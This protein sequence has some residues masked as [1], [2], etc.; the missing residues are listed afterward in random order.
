V[1]FADLFC[2]AGG[3][4]AGLIDAGMVP[5]YAC[6]AWQPALDVYRRNLG[7]DAAR[8]DLSEPTPLIRKLMK[9]APDLIAGGPPCTEFSSAGKRVEGEQAKLMAR[10]AD[11]VLACRP[12]WFVMEN[13]SRARN[14]SI[15][16]KV[17]RRFER[18]GYGLTEE[19][20]DA[21]HCGIPQ[22]RRRLILVGRLGAADD[23]L[24]ESLIAGLAAEPMSIRDAL[25]DIDPHLYFHGRTY[26]RR[27]VYSIDGPA[28][29]I[30]GVLRDP[31]PGYKRHRL[32]SANP[33]E[34]RA[35]T[36]EEL[37]LIQG[38]PP[39]W[40]W[41]GKRAAIASTTI[42][43]MIANA[44]PPAL[45]QHVARAILEYERALTA[46]AAFAA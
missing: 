39:K 24:A 16:R 35:P 44:V 45:A 19:I 25:G 40:V 31:P 2:G 34:A 13:V 21:S 36:L 7:P 14:S 26:D 9:L 38:F 42:V 4:S 43:Q 30:R 15:F 27:A 20:L 33:S 41:R 8:V 11:V 12:R 5:L 32:D 17:R 23:F 18:A 1:N 10:F 29:T 3:L 37:S 6:D 46:P 22:R 28:P